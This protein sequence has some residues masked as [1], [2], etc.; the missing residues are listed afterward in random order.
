MMGESRA[1]W[2]RWN[3][4]LQKWGLCDFAAWFLTAISPLHLLGAQVLYIGQPF[5]N[6]LVPE[7]HILELADLLERPQKRQAFLVF[8]REESSG[9]LT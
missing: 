8:L 6:M 9:D 3:Q 5:L 2:I 1:I 4:H 7:Q